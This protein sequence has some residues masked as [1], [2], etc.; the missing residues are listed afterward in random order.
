MKLLVLNKNV[1]CTSKFLCL[2]TLFSYVSCEGFYKIVSPQVVRPSSEFHVTVSIQETSQPTTVSVSIEGTT[3]NGRPYKNQDSI[4]VLPYSTR[5]AR[6]E[7]GDIEDGFYKLVVQGSGGI[8]FQTSSPLKYVKKSYSVLVQTDRAVYKP[9]QAILF[10]ALVLN[11]E[12][13]PAAE[14]RNEPIEVY[15]T[16]GRG[17]RVKEWRN[18]VIPNG[19]FFSELKLATS[20]VLGSWNISVRLHKQTYNKTFEVAQYI[21][22]KFLIDIDAPD[23]MTFQENILTAHIKTRYVTGAKV[24]GTATITCYPT[25]YSGVIQPIFQSPIRKVYPID[26][27]LT[28]NFDVSK[29]LKLND[30]FERTVIV[31]VIVEEA[32]TGRRQNNSVEVH[33]R[34]YDYR[35]DIIKSAGWYKPG[36]KYTTWIKVSNYDGTPVETNRRQVIVRHGYSRVDEVYAEEKHILDK[37]GLIKLELYP[38]MNYTNDT[39]LRIEAEYLDLKERISPVPAAVSFSNNYV[40]V[41]LETERPI[42]N[43]DVEVMVNCTE[44]LKYISYELLGRGD[45]IIANTFKI[46]SKKEFRFH[47]SATHAMVPV[48]HLIVSYTRPDGE[49]VTD[50]LDINVDGLL[51][52]FIEIQTNTLEASPESDIDMVIRSQPNSYIGIMAVDKNVAD[53]RPGNDLSQKYVSEELNEYDEGEISPYAAVT[54]DGKSKFFWKVGSSNTQDMFRKSGAI[55]LTNSFVTNKRP[56]LD[57]IYLRP[58]SYGSST[59]KPDRG[60]GFHLHTVTRPPLAGPFAFSR[61]PRPV[62]DKPKLHLNRDVAD[63]WLFMNFSS[64][65]DGKTSIRRRIPTTLNNW[66]LT[67]FSLHPLHGLGLLSS[68]KMLQVTKRFIVNVDMPPSVQRGETVAV[69]VVVVND[70]GKDNIVEVT[71]H[72]PEQKFGF[73]E[74]SNEIGGS[75]PKVELYRRKKLTIKANSAESVSFMVTPSKAGDL[76]IKA[77]ASSSSA[78]GSAIKILKVQPEGER[79]YFTKTLLLDLRKNGNVKKNITFEIPRNAVT[80]SINIEAS[81]VGDL[82]GPAIMHLDNII[83]LPTGASIP[84]MIHFYPNLIIL[85]YLR[86][87]G[88]LNPTIE[89]QAKELLETAYQEQL[90]YRTVNGSFNGFGKSDEMGTVWATAYTAIAFSQAKQFIYIEE[91]IVERAY[92]WLS[93]NQAFN[94]SFGEKGNTIHYRPIESNE[95]NSLPLTAFVVIAFMESQYY[96]GIYSNTIKKALDYIARNIDESDDSHTIAICSYALQLAKHPSKQNTFNLLDSKAKLNNTMKW[97]GVDLPRSE[98]N[99]PWHYLPRSVD[100]EA[101]AYG[102]LTFLEANALSDAIPI[103][104]WLVSN[105]NSLGG[106]ASAQDSKVALYALYKMALGINIGSNVQVE[107]AYRK[108]EMN[109]FSVNGQNALIVQKLQLSNDARLINITAEGRGIALFQVSYNYNMNVTGPWPMFTLDPQV[110]KNSDANHLQLSICT[111]FVSRNLSDTSGSNMA[112]MEV[113]FPSGFTVDTDSLPSLEVSQNV[114]K[115]ET[116]HD[117][118]AVLLYFNNI[119]RQEY[120]PTVS[121]FRT[122]KVARQKPVPV[123]IYDYYDSSRRARIFYKP[124]VVTTLCDICDEEDCSNICVAELQKQRQTQGGESS[125][126]RENRSSG[127]SLSLSWLTMTFVFLIVYLK[128]D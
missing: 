61:I 90:S 71:L 117:N 24:S 96:S 70:V 32:G 64:G 114:Q 99:N 109:R 49:F 119:T 46:D 16:D 87:T 101:T 5:I 93:E 38:P 23:H 76:E 10:R 19:V 39:A 11:S 78:Q 17:N 1:M 80:D 100:I 29:E 9:G 126:S 66:Q 37:N 107:F 120:C 97:W 103:F 92:A 27:A 63:T 69:N 108:Q 36:M 55:L 33:L 77:T 88:Q 72:N 106:F 95:G 3:D 112:V 59:V 28:V 89:K 98:I 94:G 48:S 15:I 42:V 113:N 25:I 51:Q 65:F 35:M 47:F 12:L 7:I 118:T 58:I 43:L 124:R 14:I 54:I 60:A 34:K 91:Y 82:L 74:V 41:S 44:P 57:D 2:L 26:G 116:K 104:E 56:T 86:S 111:A 50:S 128:F 13:K 84:N 6:L 68:P 21:V 67:A 8:S 121:A 18:A 127:V 115:V 83:R 73:A 22:P 110:D 30:E 105:M 122:H 81:V 20:P 102:M 123:V 75:I 31:D 53:M 52:N 4:T 125:E 40:Q 45:V 85:N 79:L 62:W